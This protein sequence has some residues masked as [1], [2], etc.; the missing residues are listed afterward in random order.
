MTAARALMALLLA[1]APAAAQRGTDLSGTARLT[2]LKLRTIAPHGREEARGPILGGEA[3][4]AV[5]FLTVRLGYAQGSLEY[6]PGPS[7]AL[8][9][10]GSVLVGLEPA[11]GLE[12]GLGPHV[13]SRL[14]EAVRERV[15]VWRLRGRYE[16]PVVT[17]LVRAYV[18]ATAGKPDQTG[19][20]FG[21]WWGGSVGL[22]VRP[23][24]GHF[25]AGVSYSIDEARADRGARRE[26]IEGLT[27]FLS[28]YL[29]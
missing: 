9:V 13:R 18:E 6:D 7:R 8:F 21:T 17:P 26:N 23:L 28:A 3:R 10:E 1:A 25:A 16:A 29:R 14:V 11:P 4:L 15:V 27:V 22:L 20:A 24:D 5:E 12:I 19:S 2:S